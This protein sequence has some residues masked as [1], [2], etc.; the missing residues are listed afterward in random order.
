MSTASAAG[1]GCP[2]LGCRPLLA[3]ELLGE[4]LKRERPSRCLH[5]ELCGIGLPGA[6]ECIQ[7]DGRSRLLVPVTACHECVGTRILRR[8]HQAEHSAAL[9]HMDGSLVF[10]QHGCAMLGM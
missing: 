10:L 6:A 5:L 8:P 3:A 9:L 1:S 7:W 2:W 4:G